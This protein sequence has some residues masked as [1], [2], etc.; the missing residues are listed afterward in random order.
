M[1]FF[2]CRNLTRK[3]WFEGKDLELHAGEVVVLRG[4]TGSGKTLF[5]RALADLDPVDSGEVFLG[6]VERGSVSP[7]E[8]RRQVLYLR[9]RATALT[10]VVGSDYERVLAL[11]GTRERKADLPT[12]LPLDHATE[13]LS[14]GELQW[15]ALERALLVEPKVL[16]L[17]EASSALDRESAERFEARVLAYVAA[18]HAA[19]WVA[20]DASLAERLG[21]EELP[22]P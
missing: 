3:P 1:S 13:K 9:Q 14:G 5:L 8:W 17:D 16:L 19:L 18:G 4:A 15:L 11:A 6:E 2:S 10:S 12:T 22:F 7:G 20:H 21:A